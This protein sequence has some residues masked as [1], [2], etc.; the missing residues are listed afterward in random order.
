M[1]LR[2]PP[3]A[4]FVRW[5]ATFEF[6]TTKGSDVVFQSMYI[7]PSSRTY[8]VLLLPKP[9]PGP[10]CDFDRLLSRNL[11]P[12]P[13]TSHRI[14][15][16]EMISKSIARQYRRFTTSHP[17]LRNLWFS[18]QIW[19]R[20]AVL[21]RSVLKEVLLRV[22][23]CVTASHFHLL[24]PNPRVTARPRTRPV[25]SSMLFGSSA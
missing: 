3:K 24:F 15:T 2:L 14:L 18:R 11:P 4:F 5:V 23:L 13:N 12:L 20:L 9:G 17:C 16:R 22:C 7:F 10:S 21:K 19:R 6:S 25:S 8:V 1:S